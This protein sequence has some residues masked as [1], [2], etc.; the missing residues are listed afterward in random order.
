MGQLDDSMDTLSSHGNISV[1]FSPTATH[2]Y[3]WGG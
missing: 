2:L 1:L 3:G